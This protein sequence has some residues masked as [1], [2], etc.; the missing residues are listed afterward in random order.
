MWAKH[1]IKSKVVNDGQSRW[2]KERKREDETVAQRHDALTSS[3][4]PEQGMVEPHLKLG[5]RS[6]HIS[7]ST[8]MSSPS[9]PATSSFPPKCVA[10]T[11]T[12]PATTSHSVHDTSIPNTTIAS[13]SA[14]APASTLASAPRAALKER[15][16]VTGTYPKL[17]KNERIF[18]N[19]KLNPIRSIYA[20]TMSAK[21]VKEKK[22]LQKVRWARAK[23]RARDH[24][25]SSSPWPS[26]PSTR[27]RSPSYSQSSSSSRTRSPSPSKHHQRHHPSFQ[28]YKEKERKKEERTTKPSEKPRSRS[29]LDGS[30]VSD[31]RAVPMS[32]QSDQNGNG[33]S[34]GASHGG[35]LGHHSQYLTIKSTS[36]TTSVTNVPKPLGPGQQP[37]S[38]SPLPTAN[39]DAYGVSTGTPP[40]ILASS[41]MDVSIKEGFKAVTNPKDTIDEAK[42]A[43]TSKTSSR[44]VFHQLMNLGRWKRNKARSIKDGMSNQ[45]T[46]TGAVLMNVAVSR[47]ADYSLQGNGARGVAS[48]SSNPAPSGVQDGHSLPLFEIFTPAD[49]SGSSSVSATVQSP[50][51]EPRQNTMGAIHDDWGLPSIIDPSLSFSQVLGSDKDGHGPEHPH[52]PAIPESDEAMPRSGHNLAVNAVFEVPVLT[53]VKDHEVQWNWSNAASHAP[54]QPLS[55]VWMRHKRLDTLADFIGNFEMYPMGAVPILFAG[56]QVFGEPTEE[57]IPGEVVE[58]L[59]LADTWSNSADDGYHDYWEDQHILMAHSVSRYSG[60]EGSILHVDDW[61]DSSSSCNTTLYDEDEFDLDPLL[62]HPYWH[63][64]LFLSHPHL[65]DLFPPI[66]ISH[67]I[68]IPSNSLVF[69]DAHQTHAYRHESSIPDLDGIYK[70]DSG[71]D[72]SIFS[73]SGSST[74]MVRAP[75]SSYAPV[76]NNTVEVTCDNCRRKFLMTAMDPEVMNRHQRW[77]CRIRFQQRVQR[78]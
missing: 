65:R 18:S 51:I 45:P 68:T 63:H 39:H 15:V 59:T 40:V 22:N 11:S 75:G 44:G 53:C 26:P 8:S 30:S 3:V 41:I 38:A 34:S 13:T 35:V 24:T 64:Q 9:T 14:Y 76:H 10:V 37:L 36:S 73:I 60:T 52:V 54:L 61:Q 17:V 56:R 33:N 49:A 42:R 4:V 69:E 62:N 55:Q 70:Q 21:M 57:H 28:E 31:R 5:P 58:T 74:P 47:V 77:M 1:R 16:V 7:T 6:S 20:Q 27:S 25:R 46:N 48:T 32:A 50:G 67:P 12:G 78:W 72:G 43:E 2:G 71:N 19:P 29:D 66:I 23:A